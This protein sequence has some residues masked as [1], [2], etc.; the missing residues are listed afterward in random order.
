MTA[1]TCAA[2]ETWLDEGM[3]AASP[4]AAPALR[5][6][7]ECPICA[8]SLAAAQAIERHLEALPAESPAG[9]T[10]RVMARLGERAPRP[11]PATAL[12][13]FILPWWVRATA[14]PACAMAFL[15]AGLLLWRGDSLLLWLRA[16]TEAIASATA[17]LLISY[18]TIST[19]FSNEIL[20]LG[21][22]SVAL[23][24]VFWIS[25]QAFRWTERLVESASRGTLGLRRH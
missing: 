11:V 19:L 5:H 22:A 13:G 12:P 25:F 4:E 14:E 23:P 16:A 1:M 2:F 3:P 9:L 10:D 6:A 20:R 17:G 8:A 21:L 7:K 18:P 15:V 24:G